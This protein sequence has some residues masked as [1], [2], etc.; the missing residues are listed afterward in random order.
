MKTVEIEQSRF[1]LRLSTED[2]S[3]FEKASKIS[4]YTTLAS[5]IKSIVR[6]RA[7]II[8]NEKE[9]ILS[10]QRD[11][12]IFFN[13]VLSNIEPSEKLKQAANKYLGSKLAK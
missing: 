5:F 11:K 1:E 6:E 2:R 8:I 3:F 4:G 12:E 10:S 7:K 13:A 9:Q